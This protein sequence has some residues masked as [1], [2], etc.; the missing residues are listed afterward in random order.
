MKPQAAGFTLVEVMVALAIVAIALTAGMQA[1]G[2]LTRGAQRQSEVLLAQTCAH[3]ALAQ[4]RLLQQQPPVGE[5]T[6]RCEQ[7]GQHLDLT[8]QVR[9][10]PN[11]LFRRID[12]QVSH[13]GLPVLRLTTIQGRS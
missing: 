9:P 12:A 13:A 8:L 1:S 4:L 5:S 11:P 2:A 3:N 6:Q 10:T 7:A